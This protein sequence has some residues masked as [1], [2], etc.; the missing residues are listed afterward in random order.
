LA[1]IHRIAERL[2]VPAEAVDELSTSIR[3]SRPLKACRAALA[4]RTPEQEPPGDELVPVVQ[5]T[6]PVNQDEV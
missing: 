1:T 2:D 6:L 5:V 3:W 4:A